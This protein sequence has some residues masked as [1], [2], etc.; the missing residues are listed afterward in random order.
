MTKGAEVI[1]T[2]WAKNLAASGFTITSGMAIGI[3]SCARRGALEANKG[4]SIGVIAT[5]ID[6]MYPSRNASLAEQIIEKGGALATEFAPR[7]PTTARTLS[8]A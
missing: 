1:D 4:I 6:C 3:D 2:S 8:S 5:G 7:H